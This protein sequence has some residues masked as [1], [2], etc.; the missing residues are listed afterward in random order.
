MI[1]GLERYYLSENVLDQFV[2]SKKS[3]NQLVVTSK[4]FYIKLPRLLV[5][6]SDM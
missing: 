1:V 6:N 2:E 5:G 4:E 3:K